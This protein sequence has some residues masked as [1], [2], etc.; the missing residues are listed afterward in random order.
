MLVVRFRREFAI[1][2]RSFRQH[3]FDDP[4]LP[5]GNRA[6]RLNLNGVTFTALTCAVVCKDLAAAPDELAVE[7]VSDHALH[8]HHNRLLHLAANHLA[9]QH[10]GGLAYF[11]H[12][13]TPISPNTILMRAMSFRSF[14]NW[15]GFDSWPVAFCIRRLNCSLCR[16]RSCVL[17]SSADFALISF[18]FITAPFGPQTSS[19]E[20]A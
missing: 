17:S 20:A 12:A 7:R 16:S 5:L 10:A 11:A 4:R 2:S 19:S 14:C 9:H 6:C 18:T 3:A 13:L 1:R 15:S 8:L